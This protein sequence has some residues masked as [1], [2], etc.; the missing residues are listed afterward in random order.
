MILR[1]SPIIWLVTIVGA[2]A[3]ATPFARAASF[4]AATKITD[5]DTTAPAGMS[6]GAAG[7]LL[8]TKDGKL[9]LVYYDGGQ[10]T[11]FSDK[12]SHVWLRQW[13]GSWGARQL[14]SQ[15]FY[16]GGE[17][18]GRHPTIVESGDG[19]LWAFWHDYRNRS[20]AG[21]FDIEIYGDKRPSG[22]NFSTTDTRITSSGAVHGGDNGYCPKAALLPDGRIALVWYDYH[23]NP[24]VSEICLRLS[25]TAG[26]FG[27][28]PAMDSLRL[29]VGT[30]RVDGNANTPFT[31]PAVA[32]TSVTLHLCWATGTG[33]DPQLYYGKYN[34]N[35]GI[36]TEKTRLE[37]N[38][39]GY[40]DPA[41]ILAAPDGAVWLVYTQHDE[42][43]N[44]EIMARR[45]PAGASAFDAAV[46]I[47]SAIGAQCQPAAA[48]DS[49]GYLNLVYVDGRSPQSVVYLKY[50]WN[51]KTA[52]ETRALTSSERSWRRPAIALDGRG[53]IYVV[54]EEEVSSTEGQLWF[55]YSAPPKN[56]AKWW[57]LMD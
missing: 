17:M 47:V 23:W 3:A 31:M 49:K 52:I 26:N 24:G 50:D 6:R 12:P 30:D 34:V 40:Y 1:L 57:F 27:A 10:E 55:S 11:A 2:L 29:T 37:T 35:T 45:R 28:A 9:T 39:A 44:D 16:N 25:D 20:T 38:A 41:K 36:L 15:S 43:G 48:F 21:P 46:K 7:S 5:S 18:G 42:S 33:S 22:G 54:W 13:S 4:V 8:W 19:T 32:A 51:T 56:A 14:L 53:G